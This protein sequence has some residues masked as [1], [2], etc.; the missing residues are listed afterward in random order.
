MPAIYLYRWPLLCFY[1][2][3]RFSGARYVRL[4]DGRCT[5]YRGNREGR[6]S[7]W[8]CVGIFA[9]LETSTASEV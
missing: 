7:R 5:R 9:W 3:Y 1:F 6:Q 2:S 4:P 8:H